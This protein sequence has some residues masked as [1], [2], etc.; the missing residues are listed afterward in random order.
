MPK[1]P[2]LDLVDSLPRSRPEAP[3]A[4]PKVWD[5]TSLDPELWQVAIPQAVLAELTAVIG[6]LRVQALSLFLLKPAYFELVA[7]STFMRRVKTHLDQ[8]PGVVLL[9]R[10]PLEDWSSEEA[11]AVYW[12]LGQL[13]AQPV[14]QEWD[15]L[16]LRDIVDAGGGQSFGNERAVTN[17][18][19]TF[20]TDNSGNQVLPNYISLLC[21]QSALSGGHSRVCQVH[22]L[23]NA[24]ARESPDLLERLYQPFL[25][26]RQGIESPG[27]A[28]VLRAP[29]VFFEQGRL[30]GRYSLNKI[31]QGYKKA[32]REIDRVGQQAL[33]I[34]VETIKHQELACEMRMERGD[35]QLINNR[36]CLHERTE[37]TDDPASGTVRHLVRM[38]Y[39]NEG[40]PFFDG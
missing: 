35:I 10:L 16:M 39:R 14:A 24:L 30:T 34:V 5:S 27:S 15:G 38:W 29:V 33:D 36:E 31:G 28:P 9:K 6:Q 3:F 2:L 22:A 37:F 40:R 1:P 20:H 17:N 23:H 8:G 12:L 32:R 26:D 13:L 7:S 4:G 18:E 25:H 21:L 19:L 11:H